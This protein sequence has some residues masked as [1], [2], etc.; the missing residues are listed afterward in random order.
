MGEKI[1]NEN[2]RTWPMFHMNWWVKKNESCGASSH[3]SG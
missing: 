2:E 1:W 3:A